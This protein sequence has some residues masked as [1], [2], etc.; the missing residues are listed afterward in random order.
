MTPTLEI[1]QILRHCKKPPY[2][3]A[4]ELE[5]EENDEEIEYTEYDMVDSES[6][7]SETDISGSKSG[8]TWQ[9]LTD[10]IIEYFDVSY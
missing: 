7:V 9:E 5:A 6:L 2:D 8:F 4:A 3:E 1:H 10:E